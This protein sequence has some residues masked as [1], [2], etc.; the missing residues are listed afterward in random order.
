MVDKV[1]FSS[2]SDEWETPEDLFVKLDYKFQFNLDAAAS[3][4]N[5]LLRVWFGEGSPYAENALLTEWNK[6]GDRVFLNP[7]YSMC[8]E[9]MKKVWE[10]IY[11]HK[12]LSVVCLLPARTDT[13]WFHNYVY[14]Q[15]EIKFLKGRL[16]FSGSKNSAPFPSMLCYYGGL[17]GL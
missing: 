14:N 11:A 7:P 13:K 4:E 12:S 2:K 8:S 10:E 6:Y 5:H 15:C 16:K 1:L 17:R 9:F 3:E